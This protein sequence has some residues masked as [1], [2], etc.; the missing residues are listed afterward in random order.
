MKQNVKRAV[1]YVNSFEEMM[2]MHTRKRGCQ[3]VV[4]GHIHTPAVKP[5]EELMYYNSG[6]WVESCTA[7]LEY[8]D[9][10][11]ELV[12]FDYDL[13]EPANLAEARMVEI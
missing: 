2:A 13:A 1:N 3:G 9:G 4:C 8:D 11:I 6:D 7:L 5:L 10:H 12:N